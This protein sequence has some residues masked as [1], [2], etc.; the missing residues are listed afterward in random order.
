[1]SKRK[2][3]TLLPVHGKEEEW[4]DVEPKGLHVIRNAQIRTEEAKEFFETVEW[5]Q[6]FGKQYPKTAHHNGFHCMAAD[7]PCLFDIVSQ[8]IDIALHHCDH[9]TL[10]YMKSH[11]D[12]VSVAAMRHKG[13]IREATKR[14]SRLVKLGWGLGRHPDT[15]APDGE[16]LVLMICLADTTQHHREFKFTCPPLGRKWSV[17]TPDATLVVFTDEAYEIWEHESVRSKW[18]DGECISLTVRIKSIDSYYGWKIPGELNLVTGSDTS[19]VGYAR[20]KQHERIRTRH[21]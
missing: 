20:E 3:S 14:G 16:G 17:F 5:F 6:R 12:D 18:Q 11:M 19:S 15:W 21:L 7:H 13:A 9:A 4:K 10:R 2:R 8:S 1:M